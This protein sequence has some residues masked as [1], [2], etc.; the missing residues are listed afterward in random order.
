[1]KNLLFAFAM[2]TFISVAFAQEEDGEFHLDQQYKMN[3]SGVIDLSSSDAKVFITGS[4]RAT[5]H[6]KIDRKVTTKGWASGPGKFSVEVEEVDGGLKIREKQEAT[7]I[8]FGYYNEEYRIELEVPEGVGLK[9]RGD[10]G[11]YFIK[12]IN[13][14]ISLRLDDADAELTDCKGSQ[15]GFFIDDGDIRMDQGKGSLDINGDDTDVTIYSGQFNEI[16][17]DID[18]GDLII[19]TSLTNTGKYELN[20]QDG[21]VSLNITSGGGEF[22][23]Q[24]DDASIS[25]QGGFSTVSESETQTKLKLSNGTAKVLVRADDARVKLAS[26]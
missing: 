16:K 3:K 24:H 17:A 4:V 2:L 15:F 22:D 25:M 1:M 26:K 20:L 18:D 7:E 8:S 11:D 21:F 12:N 13:G 6:V 5:A 23:I 14:A 19:E 10:D 9:V